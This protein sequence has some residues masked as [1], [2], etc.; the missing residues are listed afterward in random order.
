MPLKL[1]KLIFWPENLHKSSG[2]FSKVNVTGKWDNANQ[3]LA[4]SML[5]IT[6]IIAHLVGFQVLNYMIR[7]KKLA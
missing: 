7:D 5:P 4:K 2:C 1:P 6:F 3:C